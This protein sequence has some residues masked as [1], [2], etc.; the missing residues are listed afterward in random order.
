MVQSF[1]FSE[2]APVS[3][4][5]EIVKDGLTCILLGPIHVFFGPFRIG[6]GEI[7]ELLCG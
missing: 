6:F 3:F 1:E 2:V 7:G 5:R 4:I